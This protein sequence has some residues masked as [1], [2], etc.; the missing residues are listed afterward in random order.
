MMNAGPH[1]WHIRKTVVTTRLG[2]TLPPTSFL[3]ALGTGGKGAQ[4]DK[5]EAADLFPLLAQKQ[6]EAVTLRV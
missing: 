2:P 6:D 4:R 3:V 1:F 5:P